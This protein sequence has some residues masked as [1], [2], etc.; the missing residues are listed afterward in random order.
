MAAT[1]ARPRPRG[2]E[3]LL[4]VDGLRT[5]GAGAQARD[6]GGGSRRPSLFTSF[7][8]MFQQFSDFAH[9]DTKV[10]TFSEPPEKAS[11]I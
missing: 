8:H 5:P 6:L 4:D 2:G 11:Q 7:H 1:V 10:G 3:R 9:E